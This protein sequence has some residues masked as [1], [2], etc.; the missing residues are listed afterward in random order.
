MGEIAAPAAIFMDEE[1][2]GYDA[3]DLRLNVRR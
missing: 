2:L 3:L 1:L